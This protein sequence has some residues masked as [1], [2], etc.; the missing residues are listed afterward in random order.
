MAQKVFAQFAPPYVIKPPSEGASHG[1]VVAATLKELPDA[2]AGVLDRY[3]AALAEEY[4]R[5]RHASVGTIESFRGQELY[6]LPPA[7]VMLPDGHSMILPAHH[8]EGNLRHLVP[9]DFSHDEKMTLIKAAR[10]AHRA[11][12]LSHFS[13]SDFIV[14]PRAA[15]LLEVNT[16][17]GLYQGASFPPMLESVGSSV[18][19]FLEHSIQLARRNI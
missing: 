3:G 14:T 2:L 6:A 7:L 19:E 10:G 9:S 4:I 8:E 17:P 16:I 12:G 13:R 11:L 15:Y 5:G 1:I 18:R